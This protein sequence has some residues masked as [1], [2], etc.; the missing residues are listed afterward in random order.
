M[1]ATWDDIDF[2]HKTYK[3]E[4]KDDVN[5][6]TPLTTEVCEMLR[7]RKKKAKGRWIFQA[8][9]GKP[10]GHFLR[11]FKAIAKRAGL[12]CG[13]CKTKMRDGIVSST[14]GSWSK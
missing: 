10:E 3:V 14:F 4:G 11:K 13:A 8:E 1:Y 7:E 12:N 9:G 5:F 2:Q 6:V